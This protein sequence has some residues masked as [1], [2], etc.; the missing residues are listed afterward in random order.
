MAGQGQKGTGKHGHKDT[1]E[2]RPHHE[3]QQGGAQH[4]RQGSEHRSSEAGR[5]GGEHRSGQE[6]RSSGSDSLKE[7]EYRDS[8]GNI[9]HHTKTY[10]EQHG[11]DKK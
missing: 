7:R 4:S 2:P 9:H 6:N 3:G 8:Q 1:Q 11:K 5:S 10:E